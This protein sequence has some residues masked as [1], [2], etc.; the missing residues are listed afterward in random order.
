M[1][2]ALA[3]PAARAD[4][5]ARTSQL[6]VRLGL[7]E[8]QFTSPIPNTSGVLSVPNTLDLEYEL[9]SATH[10]SWYFRGTFA[11]NLSTARLSYAYAGVGRRFYLGAPGMAFDATDG[12]TRVT[13]IPKWRY[14]VGFDLGISQV[15]VTTFGT[16]LQANSGLVEPGV[17][18]G[19]IYQV[20]RS[21]GLEVSAGASPGI[22]FTSVSV[23]SFILRMLFGISYYF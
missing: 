16:A 20:G 8:G 19:T 15:V 11:Q 23:T 14:Y 12:E 5:D 6:H 10:R 13:E 2:V 18:A 4:S 17:T 21:M 22:G 1:L 3:A 9:F 7:V